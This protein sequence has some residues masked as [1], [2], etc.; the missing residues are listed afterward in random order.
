MILPEVLRGGGGMKSM[1]EDFLDWV[2]GEHMTLCIYQ[3]PWN[4]IAHTK[5]EYYKNV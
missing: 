2:T 5:N 4:F 3:N 1:K